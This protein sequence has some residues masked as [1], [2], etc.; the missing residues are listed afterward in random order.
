MKSLASTI[1]GVPWNLPGLISVFRNAIFAAGMGASPVSHVHTSSSWSTL[2]LVI[3]DKLEY[4]I[5]PGSP[6]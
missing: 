1:T 6:P 2:S 4:F 5:P 3:C